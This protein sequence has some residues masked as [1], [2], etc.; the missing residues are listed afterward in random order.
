MLA[1]IGPNW[2]TAKDE[3]GQRRL[4]NPEDFVVIEIAASISSDVYA[5]ETEGAMSRY[6]VMVDDNFH[7]MDEDERYQHGVFLTAEEAISA[8]KPKLRPSPQAPLNSRCA[9]ILATIS[10][11]SGARKT[12][13]N[14][15]PGLQ[16]WLP[17]LITVPVREEAIIEPTC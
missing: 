16:S 3:A 4:D 9:P 5:E 10:A 15:L 12:K 11:K 2:L 8:C 17:I 14:D 1:I 13:E 6:K 7:H